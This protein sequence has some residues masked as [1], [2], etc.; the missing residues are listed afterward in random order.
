M[1]QTIGSVVPLI[2]GIILLQL[3][4]GLFVTFL[5]VRMTREGYSELVVGG[6]GSA[7]F[8][9][10]ILGALLS[11]LPV[12]RVGHIR[13]F[14]ALS[15]VMCGSTLLFALI[16]HPLAWGVLRFINGL[17]LSGLFVITESWLNDRARTEI[18]GRVFSLYMAASFAA[19][20]GG[21]FLLTAYPV[22]TNEHLILVGI[23]YAAAL[24]PVALSVSPSP[25]PYEGE[26]LSLRELY[27]ISPLGMLGC[28]VCGLVYSAFYA[29][30]PVFVLEVGF[31]ATAVANFMGVAIAG[32]MILQWPLGKLSDVFDR[33]TILIVLA[34][35]SAAL[36]GAMALFGGKGLTPLIGLG[37][38]YGSLAFTLYGISVAHANDHLEPGRMVPASAG[39]MVAFGV[40][41]VIGPSVGASAMAL[42][43]APGLFGYMAVAFLALALFGLY[44][45]GVRRPVPTEEQIP[46]MAV[47]RTSPV[48]ARL[49]PRAETEE[50]EEAGEKE[51][52]P[53]PADYGK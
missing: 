20:A 51:R 17:A 21:Q 33:R 9:G 13:A 7:Y 8:A 36:S 43:G 41:A 48:I 4:S 32:G 3:G 15:A 27:R 40:G 25:E 18:R 46:Y 11:S 5:A 16:P 52:A 38:G 23:F 31:G 19:L 24:L 35:A 22:E 6:V 37:L 28:A 12:H 42:A 30:A 49:D 44:R 34:V 29:L 2:L 53:V 10:F 14:A 26:R 50:E 45:T 1:R 47:P 39:L